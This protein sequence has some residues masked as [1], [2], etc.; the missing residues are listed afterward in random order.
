MCFADF[1][2]LAQMPGERTRAGDRRIATTIGADKECRSRERKPRRRAQ[3]GI[4]NAAAAWTMAGLSL[5]WLLCSGEMHCSC[6][7]VE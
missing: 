1:R 4:A 3:G 2:G 7:G 5:P 6:K